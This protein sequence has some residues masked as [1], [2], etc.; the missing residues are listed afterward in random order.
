M[1]S[2]Y[3]GFWS[4]PIMLCQRIFGSSVRSESWRNRTA[5]FASRPVYGTTHVDQKTPM[6]TTYEAN[7]KHLPHIIGKLAAGA[8]KKKL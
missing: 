4:S 8:R 5:Q 3:V 7:A 2:L 1:P 6:Q